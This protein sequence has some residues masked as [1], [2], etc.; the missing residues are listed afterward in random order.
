[1]SEQLLKAIILL[2]AILAKVDG[3]SENEKETIKNYL[4]N[5]LNEKTALKY[6]ELFNRL[7]EVYKNEDSKISD[8]EKKT[9]EQREVE[10]VCRQIN[11]ELTH[12]QKIVLSLDLITLTIADGRISQK[13]KVLLNL[14]AKEIKVDRQDIDS[15]KSFALANRPVDLDE[16]ISLIIASREELLDSHSRHIRIYNIDGFIS[17]LQLKNYTGSFFI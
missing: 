7:I 1:M 6:F 17:I 16:D 9:N 2:F 12:H 14:I 8:K 5:R 10:K 11:A 4:L 3:V 13:E 15:I